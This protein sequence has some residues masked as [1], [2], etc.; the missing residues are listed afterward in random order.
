VAFVS[1]DFAE[2]SVLTARAL[3]ARAAVLLVA[4]DVFAAAVTPTAGLT[5]A[6]FHKARLRQPIGQIRAML[7]VHRAI[8]RHRPDV[9]HLQHGHLWFN[10]TLWLLPRRAAFVVTVHDPLPHAGD[11]ESRKTPLRVMRRGYRRADRLIAH[12]AVLADITAG[13]H[14]VDRSSIAVVPHPAIGDAS[15]H[16]AVAEVAGEI[17]FF[18]RIWAYKGLDVLIAAQPRISAHVPHARIVI[19]GRGEDLARYRALMGDNLDAFVVRNEYV[20]DD[21][22]ARLFRRAA[23][24]VLPYREASQSGVVA[25][26]ATYGRPIVATRVGALPEAIDEGVTGLLVPPGDPDALADAVVQLLGDDTLRAAMGRNA[27][28]RARGPLSP[29]AIAAGTI[30]VYHAVSRRRVDPW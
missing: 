19:A 6:P 14:G 7:A 11:D 8:R 5:V 10:L 29:D 2:Y 16:A 13:A 15:A 23:V 30:D 17:L 22:A 9:V 28:A 18:G 21:E 24:V 20:D 3:A 26:A 25:M 27:R 4:P 12:G 1:F